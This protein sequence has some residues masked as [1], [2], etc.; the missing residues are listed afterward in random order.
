MNHISFEQNQTFSKPSWDMLY[1]E[2][3]FILFHIDSGL[4]NSEW[5]VASSVS[6]WLHPVTL[7][8]SVGTVLIGKDLTTE[9]CAV[10]HCYN[11]VKGTDYLVSV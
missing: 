4:H 1:M 3:I 9:S 5:V 8:D 7:L 11:V 10:E 2:Q 6:S